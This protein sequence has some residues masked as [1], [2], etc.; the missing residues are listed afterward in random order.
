MYDICV[1]GVSAL[2]Q[3]LLTA[4]STLRV[5]VVSDVGV[6]GEPALERALPCGTAFAP[7]RL[8]QT[9]GPSPSWRSLAFTM[10]CICRVEGGCIHRADRAYWQKVFH[11]LDGFFWGNVYIL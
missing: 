6:R 7:R 5:C 2:T 3:F 1:S 10:G 9:G 4:G 8:R 11:L